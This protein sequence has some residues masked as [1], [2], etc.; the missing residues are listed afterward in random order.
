MTGGITV[1]RDEIRRY[2]QQAAEVFMPL[3]GKKFRL[4]GIAGLPGHVRHCQVELAPG[5]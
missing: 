4:A 5:Q 1:V 3:F 2:R